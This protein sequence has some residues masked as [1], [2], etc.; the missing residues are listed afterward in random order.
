MC[1]L[2]FLY[3]KY[4]NLT[5]SFVQIF[6]NLRWLRWSFCPLKSLP[7]D[8]CPPELVFLELPHSNISSWKLNTVCSAHVIYF[9]NNSCEYITM[10]D[11]IFPRPKYNLQVLKTLKILDVSHS[12]RLI[13]TP[14]F[15]LLPCLETLILQNCR[16][17]K[18]L[19]DSICSLGALKFL[20]ILDC[21]SL[22]ALPVGL[23]NIPSLVE[24]RA[25]GL[26][27]SRF[28]NSTESLSE[29][30]NLLSSGS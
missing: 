17:L 15:D 29:I 14:D 9:T 27:I 18:T 19:P 25:C 11:L 10:F 26:N 24:F 23:L 2:R 5:G 8:F 4:L 22:E 28:P 3:L 6:K 21:N 13:A 16:S 30:F 1:K 12:S 20:D 7:S